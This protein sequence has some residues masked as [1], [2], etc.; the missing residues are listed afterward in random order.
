MILLP[1][2]R[3]MLEP[4]L[5]PPAGKV[6]LGPSRAILMSGCI[7]NPGRSSLASL[8]YDAGPGTHELGAG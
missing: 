4:T 5:T 1:W 6:V 3:R 7:E 2:L 8:D